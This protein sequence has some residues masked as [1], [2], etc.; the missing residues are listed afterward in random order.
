GDAVTLVMRNH[1]PADESD[2]CAAVTES[3]D[4]GRTWAPAAESNLPL[5]TSKPYCGHLSTGQRYLVGNSVRGAN[6]SRGHLTIAVSRPGEPQL[7]HLW[8]IR[9]AAVPAALRPVYGYAELQHLAYPH[10]EERDGRLYVAYSAGPLPANQNSAELAVVP[11][12]E[13]ARLPR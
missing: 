10:A 11:V 9:D 5:S 2:I 4:G 6:H 13:L 8:L 7:S 12:E 3:R 1:S